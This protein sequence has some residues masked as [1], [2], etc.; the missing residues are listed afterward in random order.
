MNADQRACPRCGAHDPHPP[1]QN[2]GAPDPTWIP[3]VEGVL[4]L[5]KHPLTSF[6]AYVLSLVDG[7]ADIETLAGIT[8]K[9]TAEMQSLLSSL[10][11]R[12]VLKL[13][14]SAVP[15]KTV[16]GKMGTAKVLTFRQPTKPPTSQLPPLQQAIELENKGE[17]K[18]AIQVLESA[19]AGSTEPAP[20]Y[21]RLALVLVKASQDYTKA[22]SLLRKA[23]ELAPTR[24]LYRRNLAQLLEQSKQRR[25]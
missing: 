20:L 7:V 13:V 16:L 17:L 11:G 12:G 2:L 6:E 9:Q 22:E 14:E 19:L 24:D 18:A 4:D 25:P 15:A 23:I 3:V 1:A 8:G 21:N 10:A 5:A